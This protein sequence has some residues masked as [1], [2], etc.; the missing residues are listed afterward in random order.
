MEVEEQRLRDFPGDF[1]TEADPFTNSV[2]H[3]WG[4]SFLFKIII[5]ACRS[6]DLCPSSAM[7]CDAGHRVQKVLDRKD[8]VFHQQVR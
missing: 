2:G 5:F 3:F 7:R 1:L 6:S 8:T 4:M